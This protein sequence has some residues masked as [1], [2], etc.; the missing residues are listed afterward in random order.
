MIVSDDLL[1]PEPGTLKG[2]AFFGTI[3]EAAEREAKAYL[4]LSEP[5]N[6]K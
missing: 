6:K 3:W 2:L 5:K 4:G 1:P